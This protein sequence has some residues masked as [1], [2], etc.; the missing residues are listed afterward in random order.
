MY[1]CVL[2]EKYSGYRSILAHPLQLCHLD[3][4]ALIMFVGLFGEQPEL[5]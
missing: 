4:L 5:R 3:G 1:F 2:E